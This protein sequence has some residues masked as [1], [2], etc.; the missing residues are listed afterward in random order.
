LL[1]PP[2]KD[3]ERFLKRLLSIV[4]SEAF[5]STLHY[6]FFVTLRHAAACDA[7]QEPKLKLLE[8]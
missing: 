4:D 5:T 3:E 1:C 2:I 7:R 8:E 6:G